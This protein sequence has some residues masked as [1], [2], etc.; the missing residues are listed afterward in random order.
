M[1][2]EMLSYYND[3]LRVR[4]LNTEEWKNIDDY[5]NKKPASFIH[6]ME[7]KWPL[8]AVKYRPRNSGYEIFLQI[9]AKNLNETARFTRAGYNASV[10]RSECGDGSG[11][12]LAIE[13][14]GME[15]GRI[16]AMEDYLNFRQQNGASTMDTF[17]NGVLNEILRR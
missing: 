2:E 15:V 9:A 4:A 11:L 13:R 1:T 17:I 5:V 8:L 14:G 7:K 10:I 3:V 12:C 16:G 6:E